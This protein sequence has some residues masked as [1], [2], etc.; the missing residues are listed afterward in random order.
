MLTLEKVVLIQL[1]EKLNRDIGY[2]NNGV[3]LFVAAELIETG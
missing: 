3:E 1:V 2:I